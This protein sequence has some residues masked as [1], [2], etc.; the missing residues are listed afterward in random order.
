MSS[1]YIFI[2]LTGYLMYTVYNLYGWFKGNNSET[3]M[4]NQSDILFSIHSVLVYSITVGLFFYYPHKIQLNYWT[5]TYLTIQWSV[6]IYFGIYAIR[7]E[8][9]FQ[10]QIFGYTPPFGYFQTLGYFKMFSSLLKHPPQIYLNYKRKST[11]GWS[12]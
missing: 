12:I 6:F 3:G 7:K 9:L 2:N 1:N 10:M 4:V 11:K 5:F 8:T